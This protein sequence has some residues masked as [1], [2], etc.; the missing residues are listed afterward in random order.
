MAEIVT[1]QFRGSHFLYQVVLPSKQLLYCF[2]SSHHN[3]AL[4]EPIG[5]KLDIDHLVMFEHE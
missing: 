1:K 5:I 4:G 2:A 3:H